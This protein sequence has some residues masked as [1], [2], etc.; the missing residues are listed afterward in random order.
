[1][2]SGP[3]TDSAQPIMNT[4][5]SLSQPVSSR[6]VLH[7][8]LSPVRPTWSSRFDLGETDHQSCLGQV[9][10]AGPFLLDT[11]QLTV[12]NWAWPPRASQLSL[13]QPS[14][15]RFSPVY[16]AQSGSAQLSS[17]SSAWFGPAHLSQL[18]PAHLP[19]LSSA[20]LAQLCSTI[21]AWVSP[22]QLSSAEPGSP[23]PAHPAQLGSPSSAPP[24]SVWFSPAQLT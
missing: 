10:S 1:M 20:H 13:A 19:Q 16:P 5:G 9:G 3:G 15:A 2:V 22:A 4:T 21:S 7:C 14:P 24:S 6:T 18:G 23:V 8:Q 17:P 11:A 12:L